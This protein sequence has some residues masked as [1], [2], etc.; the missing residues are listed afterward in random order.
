MQSVDF[1]GIH[2]LFFSPLSFFRLTSHDAIKDQLLHEIDLLRANDPGIV[3][4]NWNGW[5]SR[6]DLFDLTSPAIRKLQ[7]A[8]LEAV[9]CVTTQLSP[10]FDWAE[11]EVQ[12][13]GWVNVLGTSGLNTPHDHPGWVWSGCYYLKVPDHENE[14]SGNIE[15]MDVRTGI[16]TLTLDGASCFEG[17]FRVRPEEG[18][19]LLFPSYLRHWVYPNDADSER[20]TLAFNI[21][22]L[23][24]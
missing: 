12:A 16:R 1:K 21:R 3:R 15:F 24:K 4:S 20:I 8:I 18:M 19:L 22:Y 13:E 10:T 6:S 5:H 2:P 11:H 7:L 17:K 14:L 9:R 23:S